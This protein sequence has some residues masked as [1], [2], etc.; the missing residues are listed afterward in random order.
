MRFSTKFDL[1]LMVVLVAAAF[2]SLAWPLIGPHHATIPRWVLPLPWLLWAYVLLATLPQY[3]EVRPEGLFIR[4][5][6]RKALIPYDS[7]VEVQPQTDSRGAG[8]YSLERIQ[9]VTREQ[10]TFI[11]A[12]RDQGG[13]LEELARRTPL[14]ERKGFGLGVGI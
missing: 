8:V 12:P 1:W 5:G 7:L 4:Q 9:V 10:G 6:V 13:F 11:I 3:Y 2:V 14:L